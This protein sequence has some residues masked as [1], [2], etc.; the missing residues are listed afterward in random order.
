MDR[1]SAAALA[2]RSRAHARGRFPQL[3]SAGWCARIGYAASAAGLV[4]TTDLPAYAARYL[5]ARCLGLATPRLSTLSRPAAADREWRASGHAAIAA[6][7]A[8]LRPGA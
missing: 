3:P 6:D 7:A 2:D 4:S 1:V 8:S 5:A